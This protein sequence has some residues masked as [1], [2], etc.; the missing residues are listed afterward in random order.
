MNEIIFYKKGTKALCPNCNKPQIEL[1]RD[2]HAGDIISSSDVRSLGADISF[3]AEFKSY[4]CDVL[5][6]DFWLFVSYE[7]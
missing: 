7:D 5:Y 2:V 4:C 3:G 1:K 6:F